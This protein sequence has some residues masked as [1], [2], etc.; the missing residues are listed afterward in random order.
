MALTS[1]VNAEVTSSTLYLK[2][3]DSH[4]GAA[5]APRGL[6]VDGKPTPFQVEAGSLV[7]LHLPDGKYSISVEADNY[8]PFELNATIA[9]AET[10]VMEVELDAVEKPLEAPLEEGLATV[11]G[12]VT[13]ADTGSLITGASI[14][15]SE[16][17]LTTTT[18]Q[19]G[20]YELALKVPQ[21]D[22]DSRTVINLSARATGYQGQLLNNLAVV[23][24]QRRRMPVKLRRLADNAQESEPVIVDESAPD[25]P[26]RTYEC[27]FDVTLR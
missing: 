4:S 25:R 8:S 2:F 5:V 9:G 15:I 24:G 10:P 16:A 27:V 22:P 19:S 17:N 18:D 3:L 1:S 11:E 6:T 14:S 23:S 7:A 26:L 12:F 20:R 13:D 21:A